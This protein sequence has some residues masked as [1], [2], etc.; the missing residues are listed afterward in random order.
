MSRPRINP[1]LAVWLGVLLLMAVIAAIVGGFQARTYFDGEK[2]TAVVGYCETHQEYSGGSRHTKTTCHG[3]WTT[4]DGTRH[5]GT[6]PNAGRSDEGRQVTLR[7]LGDRVVSGNVFG[8]L[9]PF[10]LTVGA[11][12]VIVLILVVRHKVRRSARRAPADPVRSGQSDHAP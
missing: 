7:A 11:L 2:V 3:H 10:A 1:I 9:W 12:A 5:E 8:A 4:S 6:I